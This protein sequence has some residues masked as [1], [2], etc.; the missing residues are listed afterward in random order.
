MG[1]LK[2]GSASVKAHCEFRNNGTYF[3]IMVDL[4]HARI[5][6]LGVQQPVTIEEA[7]VHKWRANDG[8]QYHT[9]HRR[10]FS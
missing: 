7:H 2:S 6:K 4:V 5:E 1:G 3:E 8:M 10:Q 9:L